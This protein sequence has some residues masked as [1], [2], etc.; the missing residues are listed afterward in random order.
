M[1]T[2]TILI[3]FEPPPGHIHECTLLTTCIKQL[4]TPGPSQC[5][6]INVT[7]NFW[8][9]LV[10]KFDYLIY[11]CY[12]NIILICTR[13]LSVRVTKNWQW[14]I[15]RNIQNLIILE[16]LRIISNHLLVY[17]SFNC[18]RNSTYKQPRVVWI[19]T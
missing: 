2:S 10:K 15:R 7:N 18:V 1:T 9:W 6:N 4:H 8:W 13:F 5:V 19:L 17:K 14:K 11:I 16:V 3:L 12:C